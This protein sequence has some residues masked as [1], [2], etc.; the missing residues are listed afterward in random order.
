MRFNTIFITVGTTNFD[1]LLKLCSQK[2]ICRILKSLGCQ[3]LIVQC[4]G[5]SC[6]NI[7]ESF[8]IYKSHNINVNCYKLKDT[9]ADDI[10]NA[11]LIISHAGAG[12][13]IEVMHANKPLVV[14]VNEELMGNHQIELAEKLANDGHC[15][16]CTLEHLNKT[17]EKVGHEQF[18][19]YERGSA[20][21]LVNKIDKLM[22]F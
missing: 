8:N 10:K 22:G 14:V 5:T 20:R 19:P 1:K 15:C 6:I 17:L 3:N 21:A 11:D 13:C 2:D 7:A 18:K 4:G 16:F 9:L 12:T